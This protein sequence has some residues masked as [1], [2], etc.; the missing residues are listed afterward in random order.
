MVK[1]SVEKMSNQT[2]E[3]RKYI[4]ILIIAFIIIV[5]FIGSFIGIK[6]TK[7]A[8]NS[9]NRNM[10]NPINIT[11]TATN[12][13]TNKT[14]S[15]KGNSSWKNKD[16]WLSG[17]RKYSVKMNVTASATNGSIK[18]IIIT[19]NNGGYNTTKNA[20]TS[21]E[22]M[23]KQNKKIFNG[24]QANLNFT[25]DGI[26]YAKVTVTNSQ[27]I[28]KT[29]K[30]RV[31]IDKTA[32][33]VKLN[34]VNLKSINGNYYTG[35]SG[36]VTCAD[37]LSGVEE[38]VAYE[39]LHN[40][41]KKI[42][43]ESA[44]IHLNTA[45]N[46]YFSGYCSDKAGNVSSPKSSTKYRYLKK[47]LGIELL[48]TANQEL[49]N[50]GGIKY[51]N[52]YGM[53]DEWCAMF[54]FWTIA[55]TSITGNNNQCTSVNGSSNCVFTKYI[56]VKSA[57]VS[58]YAEWIAK[59]KKFY[60]SKYYVKKYNSYKNGNKIYEPQPGDLIFLVSEYEYSGNPKKCD[61]EPYHI[62]I[63]KEIKNKKIYYIDG[64]SGHDNHNYSNVR[65]SSLELHSNKI[66]G[67]GHW[68]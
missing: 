17:W 61:G 52:F 35:T 9:Q 60:H 39:G 5:V 4:K 42:G 62:G 51:K 30:F 26:R 48:L 7:R 13:N 64:N 14:I 27:G 41:N 16:V 45:G 34:W 11:I 28:T 63:V 36:K 31:S 10:A 58:P 59:N 68:W 25:A 32:P 1:N 66:M 47:N 23:S 20:E 44:I 21:L 18:S 53:D 24:N 22:K 65:I 38:A 8:L 2:M 50:E 33:T 3:K 12:L 46:N 67:Y 29:V 54:I 43:K 37:S 19:W 49:G 56:N 15:E 40:S 55:H 6:F 57:V